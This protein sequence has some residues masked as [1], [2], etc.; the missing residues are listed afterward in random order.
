M[1]IRL[2]LEKEGK[3]VRVVHLRPPLAVLGRGAGTTLRIPSAEVSR[4]HCCLTVAD[5]YVTV[6]DLGSING[7]FVNGVPITETKILYPGDKLEIGPV[8]F[9]VEYDMPTV[10]LVPASQDANEVTT[11]FEV[12]EAA[13]LPDNEFLEVTSAEADTKP[14][15]NSSDDDAPLPLADAEDYVNVLEEVNRVGISDTTQLRDLLEG[16]DDDATEMPPMRKKK[17]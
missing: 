4:R 14:K 12:E 10:E 1:D 7:T 8:T 15:I 5:G 16:L 11:F 13:E 9:I 17:K 2:I 3:R 6:E